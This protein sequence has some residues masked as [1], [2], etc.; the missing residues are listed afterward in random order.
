MLRSRRGKPVYVVYDEDTFLAAPGSGLAA[1]PATAAPSAERPNR[2]RHCW[3]RALIVTVAAATTAQ[4]LVPRVQHDHESPSWPTGGRA[5][6]GRSR[7]GAAIS[8]HRHRAETYTKSPSASLLR[9]DRARR[10][11]HHLA[12]RNREGAT[13]EQPTRRAGRARQSATPAVRSVSPTPPAQRVAPHVEPTEPHTP[14]EFG[15]ED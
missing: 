2:P 11:H 3:T 7:P 5:A 10:A 9:R 8:A 1:A 6:A 14:H 15:F 4:L 12:R 13:P